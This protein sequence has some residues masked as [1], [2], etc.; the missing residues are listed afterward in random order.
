MCEVAGISGVVQEVELQSIGLCDASG[1]LHVV[2]NG[3]IGKVKNLTKDYSYYLFDIRVW[4]RENIDE[5][6]NVLREVGEDLRH[7]SEFTNDILESLEMWGVDRFTDS[8]VVIQ[9]RIKTEP[10]KQWRV[11]REMNRRI[12]ITFEAKGIEIPY[13]Q[14]TIY[15]GEPKR[16]MPIPS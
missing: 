6:I 2:P 14:Q 3:V 1:N 12:K 5:V 8:A 10:L 9:C 4:Y 11:G 7:D 13:P 15:W 16:G